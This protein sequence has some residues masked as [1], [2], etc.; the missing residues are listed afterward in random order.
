M[1]KIRL[2]T[3]RKIKHYYYHYY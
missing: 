2:I 3:K 1:T